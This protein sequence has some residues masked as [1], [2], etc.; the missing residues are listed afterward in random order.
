MTLSTA[1]KMMLSSE[2]RQTRQSDGAVTGSSQGTVS[3]Y[4]HVGL[5]SYWKIK[6][7]SP[8]TLISA[9]LLS[10]LNLCKSHAAVTGRDP[11]STEENWSLEEMF[12]DLSHDLNSSYLPCPG[13]TLG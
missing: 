8:Q 11:P 3:V 4:P 9:W 12:T 5:S 1:G 2:N 6:Q 10:G 7:S 13:V